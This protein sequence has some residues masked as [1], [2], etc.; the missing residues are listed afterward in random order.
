VFRTWKLLADRVI[1]GMRIVRYEL[2]ENLLSCQWDN[3][4]SLKEIKRMKLNL[5]CTDMKR[6]KI[7]GAEFISVTRKEGIHGFAYP[8]RNEIHFWCKDDISRK[9]LLGFFGHEVGHLMEG[10]II[11]RAKHVK[12]EIGIEKFAEAI[13][14]TIEAVHKIVK[15]LFPE[16]YE[17]TRLRNNKKVPK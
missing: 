7:T 1:A 3:E 14:K 5:V 8:D 9:K 16:K 4:L 12:S 6:H 10:E 17:R 13:R 11:K 15:K 2:L